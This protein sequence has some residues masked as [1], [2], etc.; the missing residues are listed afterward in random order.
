MTAPLAASP[1]IKIFLTIS[2]DIDPAAVEQNYRKAK[3]K[4]EQNIVPLLLD[5]TN[6]SPAIGWHNREREFAYGACAR[7]YGS[8]IGCDPSSG[9][10]K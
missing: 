5:L 8:G 7:G 3:E 1:A 9:D 10:I 6:P 4:K 2:F